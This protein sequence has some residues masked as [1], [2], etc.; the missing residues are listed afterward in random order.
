MQAQKFTFSFYRFVGNGIRSTEIVRDYTAA[1]GMRSLVDRKPEI[2]Q[3]ANQRAF[4]WAESKGLT[5]TAQE[6]FPSEKYPGKCWIE[7][8]FGGLT[9]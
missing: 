3:L 9:L 2:V 8:R 6:P 7:F 1:D 5:M 4:E